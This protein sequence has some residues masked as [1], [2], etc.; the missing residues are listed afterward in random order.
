[1]TKTVHYLYMG[2][3]GSIFSPVKLPDVY[4]IKKYKLVADANCQLTKDGINMKP[5]VVV[6]ESEVDLWYEV[7]G[8]E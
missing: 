8:Q 6:P 5:F 4:H 3:N 1:M 7:N 2:E